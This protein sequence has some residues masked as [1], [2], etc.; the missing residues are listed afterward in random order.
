[1]YVLAGGRPSTSWTLLIYRRD[2]YIHCLV[3]EIGNGITVGLLPRCVVLARSSASCFEWCLC[4]RKRI[5]LMFTID[6]IHEVRYC[7]CKI[8]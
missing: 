5:M 2:L 7:F 4:A 3:D 8:S 1:M 6:R